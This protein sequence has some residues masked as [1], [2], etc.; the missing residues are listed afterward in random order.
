[1]V[2]R[3]YRVLY[4]EKSCFHIIAGL[5]GLCVM[6]MLIISLITILLNGLY[7]ENLPLIIFVAI[8]TIVLIIGNTIIGAWLI[9]PN[10]YTVYDN[11]II[12][13]IGPY[14]T[15]LPLK[16][17]RRVRWLC[18]F[19]SFPADL[20]IIENEQFL[21]M[22]SSKWIR[23]PWTIFLSHGDAEIL[24]DILKEHCSDSEIELYCK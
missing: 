11:K 15:M 10:V 17:I 19:I 13:R 18:D 9:L 6:F 5:V 20:I 8:F 22:K 7:S 1:M 16:N 2:R 4:G 3:N 12:H 21:K 23:K 14:R 24:I